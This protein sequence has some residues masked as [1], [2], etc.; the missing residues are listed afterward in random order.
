MSNLYD[1][2]FWDGSRLITSTENI[3]ASDEQQAVMASLR[4]IK[5]R[6]RPGRYSHQLEQLQKHLDA[7]TVFDRPDG[8]RVFAAEKP[9]GVKV[10]G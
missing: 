10:I 3:V 6:R 2:T 8:L 9:R 1:V 7:P 4:A 5:H